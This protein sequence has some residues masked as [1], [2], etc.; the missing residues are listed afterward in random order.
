MCNIGVLVRRG[1]HQERNPMAGG[2]LSKRLGF[3]RFGVR[4]LQGPTD[5]SDS[6]IDASVGWVG[7][8]AAGNWLWGALIVAMFFLN[9]VGEEPI[10][11]GVLWPRQELVHGERTWLVHGFM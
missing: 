8:D 2:T 5:I 3:R 9:I 6:P 10:W 11:R 7:P 1:E 4:P